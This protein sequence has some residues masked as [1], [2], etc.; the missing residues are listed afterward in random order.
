MPDADGILPV[1]DQ[2]WFDDDL[3][4]RL[5]EFLVVTF[6]KDTVAENLQFLATS[7]GA[8]ENESPRDT[9][10]RYFQ[11]TFYTNHLSGERAYGYKNRPIYWLFSSGKQKAF[12]CLVYLHRYTSGTLAR[13]RT[14]Y[15]IPLQG[16]LGTRI[17]RLEEETE[18]ATSSAARKK[19]QT[20]VDKAKKQMVELLAYD[21]QL[22]SYADQLIALDLDDGVKV[23]YAKFGPLVADAKKVCGTKDD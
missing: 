17:T 10:R 15:V 16:K 11:D 20:E 21:E 4:L 12:Q 8:K 19:L 6:G 13:M 7:L 3:V 1:T 18:K 23:N 2:V 9:L 14:E 5:D 22:R